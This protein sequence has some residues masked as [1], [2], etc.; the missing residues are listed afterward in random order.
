MQAELDEGRSGVK[1][2][3]PVDDDGET[4]RVTDYFGSAD[5]KDGDEL[6]TWYGTPAGLEAF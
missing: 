2:D 6:G 1:V 3:W 4:A 5:N